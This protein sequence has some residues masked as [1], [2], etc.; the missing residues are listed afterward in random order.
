MEKR[1]GFTVIQ[2]CWKTYK[3]D[4]QYAI[5]YFLGFLETRSAPSLHHLIYDEH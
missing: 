4:G 1:M 5:L 3:P 2:F